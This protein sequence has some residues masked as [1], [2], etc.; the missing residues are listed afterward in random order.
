M[1]RL[2]VINEYQEQHWFENR[3]QIIW[4][5]LKPCFPFGDFASDFN[6]HAVGLIEILNELAHSQTK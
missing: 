5:P 2:S 4:A 3:K 6:C 1:Y